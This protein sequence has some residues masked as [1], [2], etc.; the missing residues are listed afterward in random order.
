MRIDY[1]ISHIESFKGNYAIFTDRSGLF[2]V[3]DKDGKIIFTPIY[4]HIS[5]IDSL[6]FEASISGKSFPLYLDITGRRGIVIDKNF[7]L[8]DYAYDEIH[9]I[10]SGLIAV[11]S[12]DSLWGIVTLQNQIVLPIEYEHIGDVE[13]EKIV[14]SKM[15]YN[16]YNQER[17]LYYGI[18]D[19]VGNFIIEPSIPYII[20][21]ISNGLI[22]YSFDYR[23]WNIWYPNISLQEDHLKG[24]ISI[25]PLTSEINIG[26]KDI[27]NGYY[28]LN[29]KGDLFVDNQGHILSDNGFTN[30]KM[31]GSFIYLID[32]FDSRI[33][34]L[35]LN[36]D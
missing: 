13:G 2:G 1:E 35:S 19:V 33:I 5:M 7:I 12:V 27:F 4:N 20:F 10:G 17:M 21:K 11:S 18:I 36:G 31:K 6:H 16:K 15:V 34:I 28:L 26:N 9:Y 23:N 3:I 14:I 32:N 22:L 8:F 30:I 25:T 29:S 24:Y